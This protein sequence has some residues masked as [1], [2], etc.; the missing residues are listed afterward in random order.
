[1]ASIKLETYEQK[2]DILPPGIAFPSHSTFYPVQEKLVKWVSRFPRYEDPFLFRELLLFYLLAGE[3]YLDYHSP[4][5]L[6]RLIKAIYFMQKKLLQSFTFLNIRHLEIRWT[7]VRLTFPFSS[8]LVLGCLVGFNLMEKYEVFDD[9]SVALIL[10]KH[11]PQFQLVEGSSY[12]HHSHSKDFKICYFEIEKSDGSSF[13]LKEQLYLRK[14]LEQKLKNGIQRLAPKIFMKRNEEEVYKNILILSE[15]ILNLDD[16]PQAMIHLDQQ[17]LDEI[18]F[19]VT[20]V[21]VAPA[22]PFSLKDSFPDGYFVSERQFALRCLEN[23]PIEALIFRIHLNR[24]PSFLRSDGSLNFYSARRHAADCLK[25]TIGEFRDYNGG[26]LL[27]QQELLQSFKED[28]P[29]IATTDVELLETFFYAITPL[30]KQ[31]LLQSKTISKLFALFL[32]HT[33][34][35]ETPSTSNYLLKIMHEEELTL[36]ALSS[37]HATLKEALLQ[38]VKGDLLKKYDLTYN[39]IE[40]NDHLYFHCAFTPSPANQPFLQTFQELLASCEKRIQTPQTLRISFEYSLLSLDPRKGGDAISQIMSGLLFEGLT[41]FDGFGKIRNGIAEDI[42]H[43]SDYK[44]YTFHLRP[45][46]WNDGSPLTAYDFEYTWKKILSPD[47]KT[48][49]AYLFYPIKGAQ[50][51]KEGRLSIEELGVAALDEKTLR[52]TLKNPTPYFL[53]LTSHPIYSPVHRIIDQ[54]YPQWPYQSGIHYPCN[55]PFVLKINTPGQRYKM[56]KNPLY[57]DAHNIALD[58]VMFN[59]MTPHQAFDAFKKGEIDWLGHPLGS[60]HSFYEADKNTRIISISNGS[61]C[62]FVFNTTQGPF[63]SKKLRQAIAYALQRSDLT[64]NA[65]LPI[66]PAY[67]PLP[68]LHSSSTLPRFP[69]NLELARQLWKEGWEE[70]GFELKQIPPLTLFYHHKGVREHIADRLRQQLKESFGLNCELRPQ[71]WDLHFEK[72]AQGHFQMGLIQ[73]VTWVDDPIYTLN[74][75]RFASEDTNFPKWEHP[76]FQ[77]LLHQCD[78]ETNPAKRMAYFAAAED[79]LCQE[80]P[81]IPLFYQPFQALMKN[82]LHVSYNIARATFNF[83]R[84]FYDRKEILYDNKCQSSI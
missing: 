64:M 16:L 21:Y 67:S 79:L 41:W 10:Q 74:A 65:P 51:A 7:P 63:R 70:L 27:K 5:S 25:T 59:Q 82:S 11:F 45:S 22:S 72:M 17:T 13:S 14:N 35:K 62:W 61:I 18:V 12:A 44:E 38:F 76:D 47:F 66:T 28:Y 84:C 23:R 30:E 4:S 9:E 26:I 37:C 32:S 78:Q 60:W 80:A 53:E 81:I 39:I 20:L 1:M 77:Q 31:I 33:A 55:G 6:S 69:R 46:V 24:H 83:A 34:I 8:K 29:H 48:S 50:E 19:L 73:W 15:Q 75:F 40:Q 57:W 71:P 54:R 42:Q 2:R 36:L 68:T 58:Q 43:T 3:K 52:V 56:E 49:F